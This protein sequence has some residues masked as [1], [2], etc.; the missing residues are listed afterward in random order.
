MT[1]WVNGTSDNV[2]GTGTVA[3]QIFNSGAA[4]FKSDLTVENQ[5][6]IGF[7]GNVLHT[8]SNGSS[9]SRFLYSGANLNIAFSGGTTA[10]NG[11]FGINNYED[12]VRL[13]NILNS[14]TAFFANN[15]LVN[16]ASAFTGLA[17]GI[18]VNGST[19]SGVLGFNNVKFVVHFDL[20]IGHPAS[21][22]VVWEGRWFYFI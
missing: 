4:S 5:A 8:K 7:V 14:G 19:S 21:G 16:G 9:Y 6:Y 20:R 13:F 11:G 10:N 15:V 18:A 2:N 12:T 22:D 1:F 17:G 3:L